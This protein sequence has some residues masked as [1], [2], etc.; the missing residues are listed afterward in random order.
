MKNAVN[1]HRSLL[2]IA[3]MPLLAALSAPVSASAICE[4]PV[5]CTTRAVSAG[6]DGKVF[7]FASARVNSRPAVGI[8]QVLTESGNPVP[9]GR[10][11][12][13]GQTG[14]NDFVPVRPGK[15]MLRVTPLV[16]PVPEGF[17]VRGKIS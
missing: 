14:A 15:Y 8:A 9:N 2:A 16:S 6:S 3:A 17:R 1:F 13:N 7:I 12:F 4:R 11:V 5:N 10:R